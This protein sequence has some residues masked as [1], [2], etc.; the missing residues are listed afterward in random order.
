MICLISWPLLIASKHDWYQ[1]K[2]LLKGFKLALRLW[3]SSKNWWRYDQMKFVTDLKDNNNENI[4]PTYT[5]GS[6]WLKIC[7]CSNTLT[8]YLTR[9]ITNHTPIGEYRLRFF[10]NE[11]CSYPCKKA[12]IKMRQHLPFNSKSF[13]KS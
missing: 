3:E 11:L 8:A 10:S 7:R 6:L 4:V 12:E 5:K 1:L 9:L 2:G 13:K